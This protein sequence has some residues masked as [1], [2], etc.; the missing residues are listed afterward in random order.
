MAKPGVKAKAQTVLGL[1]DDSQ[2]GQGCL[3][4]TRPPYPKRVPW[5]DGLKITYSPISAP[6]P[7]KAMST[8]ATITLYRAWG[9]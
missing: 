9:I 1:I 4:T 7:P 2:L 8:F 3:Y 5:T 6:G